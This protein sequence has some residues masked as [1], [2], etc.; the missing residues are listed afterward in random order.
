MRMSTERVKPGRTK[1][2][3]SSRTCAGSSR[4][5]CSDGIAE[6][7]QGEPRDPLAEPL[8]AVGG[9]EARERGRDEPAARREHRAPPLE[10]ELRQR[11]SRARARAR[12]RARRCVWNVS[13]PVRITA[14]T[15]SASES[16]RGRGVEQ[17]GRRAPRPRGRRSA[18]EQ[19]LLAGEAAVDGGP[20]AAG[21]A[22]DVVEGG[23]GERRPGRRTRARR[24]GSGR[25]GRRSAH[26]H[27]TVL[28]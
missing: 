10:R 1:S 26:L 17:L 12:S 13:A 3:T 9:E 16:A 23:L 24:R 22:G 6:I 20:G 25:R 4:S 19:G 28:R 8:G 15:A 14:T 18:R 2:S 5:T 11:R 21:L 27:E 7:R